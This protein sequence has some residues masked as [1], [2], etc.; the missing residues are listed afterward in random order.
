[1]GC[2][3]PGVVYVYAPGRGGKNAMRALEGFKGVLQVDGYLGALAAR[4]FRTRRGGHAPI[5]DEA[6]ALLIETCKLNGVGPNAY[7][8]ATRIV[9]GWPANRLDELLPWAYAE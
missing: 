6:I 1:L 3:P 7:L 9:N 2:R 5:A 4:I 8:T